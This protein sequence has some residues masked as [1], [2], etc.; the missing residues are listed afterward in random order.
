[1]KTNIKITSAGI[2]RNPDKPRVGVVSL[3]SLSEW[4]HDTIYD[5]ID[6]TIEEYEGETRKQITAE[7]PGMDDDEIDELVSESLSMAG[8]D[9]RVILFGS[10]KKDSDGRYTPDTSGE[11][12]AEYNSDDNLVT[13]E[14]SRHTVACHHTSPCFVMADG[15]GPCGDLDKPGDSVIAYTLPPEFFRREGE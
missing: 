8:F 10:W 2:I 13:V 1:M 7:N 9:S 15:S 12:S 4:I 14:W 6:L 3:N 5:G 11:Y